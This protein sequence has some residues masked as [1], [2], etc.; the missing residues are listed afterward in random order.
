MDII[1]LKKIEGNNTLACLTTLYVRS[2]DITKILD[3]T[4]VRDMK[5][6]E[7]VLQPSCQCLRCLCSYPICQSVLHLS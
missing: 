4:N 1:G 5:S 7:Q 6:G 3:E 2:C